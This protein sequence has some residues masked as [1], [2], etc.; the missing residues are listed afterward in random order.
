MTEVDPITGEVID[1]PGMELVPLNL[2]ALAEDELLALFPTPVQA[3]GALIRAR[4]ANARIPGALNEYR[5]KFRA[6]ENA[7][8]LALAKAVRDLAVEFPRA[9]LTERRMLAVEDERVKAA[10]DDLDTAWLLFEFAR[11]KAKAVTEDIDILRSIN[12]NFRQEHS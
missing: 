9:T 10:Q 7:H 6:A 2:A 8:K 4:A 3:A 12:A 11:D 1:S 5:G